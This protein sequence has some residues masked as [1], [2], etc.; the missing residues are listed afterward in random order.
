MRK[1]LFFCDKCGQELNDDRQTVTL[2]WQSDDPIDLCSDCACDIVHT[3]EWFLN[4][5]QKI[6]EVAEE[7]GELPDVEEDLPFVDVPAE[8]PTQEEPKK[9]KRNKID[10]GKIKALYNAGWPVKEIAT[11]MHLANSVI[12]NALYRLRQKGEIK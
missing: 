5:S 2:S 4:E 7:V 12:S 3:L 6:D 9:D 1:V 11:E 10:T 8:E